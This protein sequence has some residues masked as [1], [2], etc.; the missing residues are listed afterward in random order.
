MARCNSS[1]LL[2][3]VLAP[4]ACGNSTLTGVS[5]SATAPGSSP[6]QQVSAQY[7]L[8]SVQPTP[9]VPATGFAQKSVIGLCVDIKPNG[10]MVQSILY[11]QDNPA[12]LTR[13]TDTWTYTLSGSDILTRG[14]LAGAGSVTQRIG[15][16]T[17]AQV[18]ITRILRNNGSAIVR[19]LIFSKVTQLS[20]PCS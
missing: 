16:T 11:T 3:V 14:P 1:I 9:F 8:A 20:T 19:T 17:D 15:S 5:G 10:T 12:L 6:A 18:T 4:C 2:F 7:I 13:E